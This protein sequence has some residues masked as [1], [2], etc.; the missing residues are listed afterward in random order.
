MSYLGIK[1]KVGE[2]LLQKFHH[3]TFFPMA[4][5]GR[6][7]L[8]RLL[9][10]LCVLKGSYATKLPRYDWKLELASYPIFHS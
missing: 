7:S 2:E 9:V 1:R 6:E 10:T 4:D 8:C 3:F 5:L